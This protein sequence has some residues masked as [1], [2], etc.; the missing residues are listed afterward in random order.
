MD[1]EADM[2]KDF[3]HTRMHARTRVRTHTHTHTHTHSSECRPQHALTLSEHPLMVG[4]VVINV[5]V[6]HSC[7]A[8]GTNPM[9]VQSRDLD[10]PTLV[11][12]PTSQLTKLANFKREP[13]RYIS[14]CYG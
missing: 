5:H 6:V 9:H 11:I 14:E 4:A 10:K 2:N 3:T 7:R 12:Q 1:K 13:D 8:S